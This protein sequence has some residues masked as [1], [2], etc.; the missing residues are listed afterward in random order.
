MKSPQQRAESAARGV[1]RVTDPGMTDEQIAL[2]LKQF[3]ANQKQFD[4]MTAIILRE[5]G[6]EGMCECA[7]LLEEI[8][9]CNTAMKLPQGEFVLI[10]IN[11]AREI[12]QHLKSLSKLTPPEA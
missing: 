3:A 11:L 5:T 7:G 9:A 4:A 1:L 12:K 2:L 10:P 6:L 8:N